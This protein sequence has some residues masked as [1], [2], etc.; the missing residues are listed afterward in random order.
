M[1]RWRDARDAWLQWGELQVAWLSSSS[2][3]KK[4]ITRLTCRYLRGD[5]Q[6]IGGKHHQTHFCMFLNSLN[7]FFDGV[8]WLYDLYE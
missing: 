6:M 3:T 7:L 5:D 2:S 8:F 1:R 4:C